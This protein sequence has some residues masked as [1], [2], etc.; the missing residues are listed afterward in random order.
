MHEVWNKKVAWFVTQ[1]L[2]E[3]GE[4]FSHPISS[5]QYLTVMT[6]VVVSHE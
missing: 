6:P 5:S 2:Y 4:K 3:I 1:V